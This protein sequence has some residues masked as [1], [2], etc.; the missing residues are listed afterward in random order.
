MRL[1]AIG[2]VLSFA[3]VFFCGFRILYD[4]GIV[5]M[6]R[7]PNHVFL[8]PGCICHGDTV[9]T[10]VR[11][12]IEGPDSVRE[13]TIAA[14]QIHVAK[15]SNVAAGFN[16][17]AFFG[18]LQVS[19]TSG[20]QL[21]EPN[22]GDSLELTHTHPKLN[23]GNDTISWSFKYRAPWGGA[24]ID[25][26]YANGNSVNMNADPDGDHWDFAPDFLIRVVPATSAIEPH[27]AY[28]AALE[29]NYPNPFNP[30]T[31]IAFVLAKG[32]RVSLTV[33]DVAGREVRRLADGYFSVGRHQFPFS[34]S[35]KS[36]AS[37]IYLYRLNIQGEGRGSNVM[38]RKMVLLR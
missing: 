23:D 33:Y 3:A 35:D 28:Q 12:W 36:L 16:V 30:E 1:R 38:T 34:G 31:Q 17:A 9:S 22:A 25:T 37:G 21:M 27:I 6:T 29:Q 8:N 11:V 5:G 7:K 10:Q 20:T 14:Y 26:L 13:G 19:D 18:S 24:R 4:T 2:V 15:D 32:S